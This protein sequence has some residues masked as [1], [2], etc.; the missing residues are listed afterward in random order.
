MNDMPTNTSQCCQ[1]YGET[2]ESLSSFVAHSQPYKESLAWGSL[3]KLLLV[4]C[5][6]YQVHSCP[7]AMSYNLHL[8]SWIG[9][10]LIYYRNAQ[11]TGPLSSDGWSVIVVPLH[12]SLV[13]IS[14][15]PFGDGKSLIKNIGNVLSICNVLQSA[16]T[17]KNLTCSNILQKCSID[18]PGELGMTGQW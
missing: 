7:F 11:L 12:C 4:T 8:P 1:H 2:T 3:K 18:W 16:F 9:H 6:A 14:A 15:C 17:I 10:A 13:L 5:S